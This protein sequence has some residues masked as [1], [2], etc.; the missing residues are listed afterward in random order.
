MIDPPMLSFQKMLIKTDQA[1]I[2]ASCAHHQ[3]EQ[4]FKA[5]SP[6][7]EEH[8]QAQGQGIVRAIKSALQRL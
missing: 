8:S 1:Q 4:L 5:S 7:T 2:R 3:K 6:M